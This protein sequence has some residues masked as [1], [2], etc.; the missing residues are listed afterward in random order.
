M[1]ERKKHDNGHENQYEILRDHV[2]ASMI[3]KYDDEHGNKYENEIKLAERIQFL[4]AKQHNL[5]LKVDKQ[6]KRTVIN[7]VGAISIALIGIIISVANHFAGCPCENKTACGCLKPAYQAIQTLIL[8]L[9]ILSALI[10]CGLAIYDAIE[11]QEQGKK[12][13]KEDNGSPLL[14]DI[15]SKHSFFTIAHI[16]ELI[17]LGTLLTMFVS[18]VI[19]RI[20]I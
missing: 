17:L 13:Q 9:S 3:K 2:E 1:S 11:N 10:A 20:T 19:I 5:E 15:K 12:P 7:I 4:E 16:L 8:I 6:H 18:L 14:T